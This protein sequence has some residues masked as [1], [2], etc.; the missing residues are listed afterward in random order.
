MTKIVS[1][2]DDAYEYLKSLKN[3][4]E[5]FSEV[6]RRLSPKKDA[7]ELLKFAGILKNDKTGFE[8]GVREMINL[9]KTRKFKIA[10]FE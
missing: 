10:K 6:V 3:E 2:A 5:S 7:R 8:K 1:L 4:N 9:R